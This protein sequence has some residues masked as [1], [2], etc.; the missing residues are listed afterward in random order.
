MINFFKSDIPPISPQRM[1]N[2]LRRMGWVGFWLQVILGFIPFLYL[3]VRLLKSQ[4]RGTTSLELFVVIACL[5]GLLLTMYW[6]FQ[7]VR[8]G[9]KLENAD[10]RRPK[11]AVLRSLWMGLMINIVGMLC[12]LLIALG[13]VGTLTLN[14]LSLPQGATI[15]TPGAGGDF[16]N[17]SPLITPSDM[18]TI[19]AMINTIAAELIGIIIALL[20]LSKMTQHLFNSSQDEPSKQLSE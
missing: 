11:V 4:S 10:L 8:L 1:A 17:R 20:L 5:V 3:I 19:Q 7:Y 6:S 2:S 18:I 13:R 15:I 14:M 12:A 9:R 16:S